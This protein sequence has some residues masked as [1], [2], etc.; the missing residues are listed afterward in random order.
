MSAKS[1][2][3]IIIAILLLLSFKIYHYLEKDIKR[4]FLFVVLLVITVILGELV[5]G[6]Y[7]GNDFNQSNVDIQTE[8][9]N[10]VE[11]SSTVEID[12]DNSIPGHI[13]D[14]FPSHIIQI[15]NIVSPSTKQF[16]REI[17]KNCFSDTTMLFLILLSEGIVLSVVLD[18]RFKKFFLSI[19]SLTF[20]CFINWYIPYVFAYMLSSFY[21]V[22]SFGL[23]I[24]LICILCTLTEMVCLAEKGMELEF[25]S[26]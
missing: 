9:N 7:S 22:H 23:K 25:F 1:V 5:K 19:A 10:T 21:V 3:L 11:N 20:I 24:L 8:S 15:Y 26:N 12:N 2:L 14:L 4:A 16:A 17:D 18:D 13:V 6:I